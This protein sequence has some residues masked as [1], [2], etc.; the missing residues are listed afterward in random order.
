MPEANKKSHSQGWPAWILILPFIDF[1]LLIRY[2][3][4]G[5]N[6]ALF[7]S[8]GLIAHEQR[9]L[10]KVV[11]EE[12]ICLDQRIAIDKPTASGTHEQHSAEQPDEEARTKRTHAVSLRNADAC[13]R[14]ARS[15]L[16]LNLVRERGCLTVWV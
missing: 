7:N 3:L 11:V 14:A 10:A 9:C 8:K 6:V 1:V 4:R 13:A 16:C 12:G 5:K 2:L 15:G